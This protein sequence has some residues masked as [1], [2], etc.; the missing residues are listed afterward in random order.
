MT[1]KDSV[2]LVTGASRGIGRAIAEAMA[3]EGASVIA[4]ARN[5]DAI[6]SWS[7]T[8]PELGARIHPIALDV[9]D[10]AACDKAV[11]DA[12][13]KFERI[14]ILVNNAGITR[15]GLIMNMED[16]QFDSVLDTNLRGAFYLMRA[17]SRHMVRARKGR[18]IN[19]SSFSGLSGNAGQANYAA[20][21]AALN[22]LTK[23]MAKE[24]SKRGVLVNAIAPGF[25][26]TDMTDVLPDKVKDAVRPL[27]PAQRFGTPAEI[28]SVAVFLAGPGASYITGQIL[29]VDGGLHM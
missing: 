23:T 13:A 14:D 16:D 3:R 28:A 18:I 9:T 20:S 22:A 26:E 6:H 8:L 5:T 10:R 25:I 12:V 27:I 17:V 4:A 19:I 7:S 24:I 21:K 15:D 29:S 1:L 11:D 2:A